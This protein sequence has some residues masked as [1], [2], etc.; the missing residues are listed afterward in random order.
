[1][2]RGRAVPRRRAPARCVLGRST[3]TSSPGSASSTACPAVRLLLEQVDADLPH[4][5]QSPPSGGPI[6]GRAG[7]SQPFRDGVWDP[8]AAQ[9]P[10]AGR[11]AVVLVGDQVV[12]ALAGPA[13]P[14]GPWHADR[15]KD[16]LELGAVVAL[17][18]ADD[19]TQWLAALAAAKVD[20]CGQPTP[21]PAERLERVMAHP[22][23]D[24]RRRPAC[25]HPRHTGARARWLSQ[26]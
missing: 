17:A 19:H 25:A 6:K 9:Q 10:P 12:G 2:A 22:L 7:P 23:Y 21:G 14:G 8:A 20:L 3:S 26:R 13:A 15:V 4:V 1:M 24:P 16:G 5:W 11:V 18:G